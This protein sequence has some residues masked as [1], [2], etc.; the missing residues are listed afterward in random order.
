MYI[1]NY[2]YN[3]GSFIVYNF[4]LYNIKELFC[5]SKILILLLREIF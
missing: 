3:K 2:L 5:F 1:F 4:L